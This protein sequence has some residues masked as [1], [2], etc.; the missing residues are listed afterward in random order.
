M[1]GTTRSA[2]AHADDAG[3]DA[4]HLLRDL[5]VVVESTGAT[6]VVLSGGQPA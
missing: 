2:S 4:D 6:L 3:V 1:P 5:D